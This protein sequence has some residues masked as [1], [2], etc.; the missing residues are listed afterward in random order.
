MGATSIGVA[1]VA[2]AFTSAGK[3]G[4]AITETKDVNRYEYAVDL[5]SPTK[6]GGMYHS[7]IQE[8]PTKPKLVEQYKDKPT[9]T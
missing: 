7:V 6:E 8:D 5:V 2:V 4:Y 1:V 9:R 3:F